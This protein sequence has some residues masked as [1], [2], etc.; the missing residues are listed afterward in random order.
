MPKCTGSSVTR[1]VRVQWGV[2][3]GIVAIAALAL[4]ACEG[5]PD[6]LN[7]PPQGWSSRQSDLHQHYT[8]ML[9]N[10]LLA[11]RC[12]TDVHFVPHT[13]V[14]NSN[15][16]RRLDRYAGLLKEYGGRLNYDAAIDDG[17]LIEKRVEAV[18]VYLSAAGVDMD[19]II[20][21]QGPVAVAGMS[22][23]EA[24]AARRSLMGSQGKGGEQEGMDLSSILGGG[25]K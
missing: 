18:R 10:T 9:D 8:Y 24:V 7:A 22:A 6:R 20:V 1:N 16:A 25:K 19:K 23:E 3:L 4:A 15:G 2:R 17:E 21:E 12:V 14:L 11:E 5:P 13:S